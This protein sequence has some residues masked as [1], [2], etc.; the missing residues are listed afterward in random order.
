MK[1]ISGSSGAREHAI[2]DYIPNERFDKKIK[3]SQT[4][5]G[6]MLDLAD[7]LE[8]GFVLVSERA[9]PFPFELTRRNDVSTCQV[10]NE[11]NY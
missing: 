8:T 2:L 9:K 4:G 10:C 3:L 5:D 7:K 1:A 6:A 11:E